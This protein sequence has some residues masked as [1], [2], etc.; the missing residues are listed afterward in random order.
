MILLLHQCG[1][2]DNRAQ[3]EN[4][5]NNRDYNLGKEPDK[6]VTKSLAKLRIASLGVGRPDECD[7]KG[8]DGHNHAQDDIKH[9]PTRGEI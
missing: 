6:R 1:D 7:E 8:D 4:D 2:T 3:P 5:E 9:L